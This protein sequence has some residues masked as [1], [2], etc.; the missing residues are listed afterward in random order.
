VLY[1]DYTAI[2][3]VDCLSKLADGTDWTDVDIFG[4]TDGLTKYGHGYS[5]SVP[6]PRLPQLRKS[7]A[8]EHRMGSVRYRNE[9]PHLG[10]RTGSVLSSFD[11][12]YQ[13]Q[14]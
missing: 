2:E 9:Q 13:L 8:G 3:H 11:D 10:H 12:L 7:E 5:S 6:R 1:G 4:R 14:A